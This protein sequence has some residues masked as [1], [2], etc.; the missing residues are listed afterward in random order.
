MGTPLHN[1]SLELFKMYVIAGVLLGPRAVRLW[2]G[3]LLK[4]DFDP[5]PTMLHMWPKKR[6]NA[7][8]DLF[9]VAKFHH[10]RL[11]PVCS[12]TSNA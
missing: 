5:W 10:I 7:H 9:D 11:V 8:V 3:S 12:P 4:P 2:L 1:F 6:V